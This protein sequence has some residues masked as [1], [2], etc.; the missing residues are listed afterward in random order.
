[1]FLC[2]LDIG[3]LLSFRA[4][5]QQDDESLYSLILYFKGNIYVPIVSRL[6]R[7]GRFG[8]SVDTV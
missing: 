2:R 3:G 6:Y 1:M 4:A 5:R 7:V 8:V